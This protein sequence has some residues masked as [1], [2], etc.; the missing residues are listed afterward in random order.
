[1]L[2]LAYPLVQI[3]TTVGFSAMQQEGIDLD[4]ATL[5]SLPSILRHAGPATSTLSREKDGL[6]YVTR[7]TLPLDMSIFGLKAAAIMGS[8]LSH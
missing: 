8:A 4:A 1:M 3:F 6:L 2:K 5:P 7:Q